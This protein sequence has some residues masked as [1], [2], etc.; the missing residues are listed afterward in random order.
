MI[1]MDSLMSNKYSGFSLIEVLF[2]LIL[3]ATLSSFSIAPLQNF[4]N[5]SK[6]EALANNLYTDIVS[7]RHISIQKNKRIVVCPLL[8]SGKCGTDWSKGWQIMDDLGVIQI[9]YSDTKSKITTSRTEPQIVFQPIGTSLGHNNTFLICD[10]DSNVTWRLILNNQ[11]RLR[12]V[13]GADP[14]Q[15]A[16]SCSTSPS[17]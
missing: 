7:A 5:K 17:D 11:G 6:M 10:A 4:L 16:S 13:K 1:R 15:H 2:V 3:V 12:Q 9:R 14:L 8:E